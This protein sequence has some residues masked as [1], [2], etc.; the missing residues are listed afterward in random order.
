MLT[1]VM[2][3]LTPE[4]PLRAEDPRGHANSAASSLWT[5][6]QLQWA[7]RET[8]EVSD[9]SA[10]KLRPDANRRVIHS[11]STND[12]KGQARDSVSVISFQGRR[13]QF[14]DYNDLFSTVFASRLFRGFSSGLF[15]L[16]LSPTAHQSCSGTTTA[17]DDGQ[18]FSLYL[19]M[20]L[21]KVCSGE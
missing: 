19:G 21:L 2:S 16:T 9:T 3:S 1:A 15:V 18:G 13:E 10:P 6:G 12:P 4:A 5:T 11:E 20:A 8:D 7:G 14:R 17:R